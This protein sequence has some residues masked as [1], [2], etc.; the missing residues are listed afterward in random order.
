MSADIPA[1]L[2][3]ENQREE[4]Q[5]RP[6]Q[7]DESPY[8]TLAANLPGGA[9]FLVDRDLRYVIAEGKA[10]EAA[11]F[12]PRQLEG[13]TIRE[14]LDPATATRYEPYY[15]R[16]LHGESFAYEHHSHGRYFFS[17]GTP[18]RN[19]AGE[20]THV[21]AVSYDVTERRRTEENLR[22][23]LEGGQT[24]LWDYDFQ[25]EEMTWSS[26][27]YDLLGRE[28]TGEPS[29]E[30]FFSYIHEEDRPRVSEHAERW[31][32]EGGEFRDEF[33]ILRPDGQ[34]RWLVS[35]AQLFRDPDGRR[36]RAT[37]VNYD[38][39]ERKEAEQELRLLNETL[40]HRVAER[41]AEVERKSDQLRALAAELSRAEQR[42]RRRLAAILHDHIQQ[43]LVGARMQLEWLRWE[44]DTERFQTIMQEMD[45]ILQEALD[46][47]RNL[48]VSISP[49]VL[50]ETGLIGGLNWLASRMEEKH[51]FHVNLRADTRAEPP[52]EETRSLLFECARELLFNA[53]KHAEVQ[54]A[55]V[56]VLRK[57]GQVRV[58]VDD[59]GAG[60]NPDLLHKR[61]NGDT[62]F[63]LFSIQERL[64]HVGGSMAL[65]SSPGKGT[66][67]TL[68]V[69]VE[70]QPEQADA[71]KEKNEPARTI[72]T[73]R[74]DQLCR[75]LIVDDHK[76]MREGLAGVL[77]FESDI[78]VVGE[79]ADGDQA[80]KLADEL[81]PDVVIMDVN[82]GQVSGVEATRRITSRDPQVQVIGLSMHSDREVA[83]AMRAAGATAF[84]AKGGPSRDLIQSIRVCHGSDSH[85]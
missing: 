66:T 74:K 54:E 56:T 10:L 60:F 36:L 20:V 34:E 43:L 29:F 45:G 37:G 84:L 75:V 63:G 79:A 61:T 85:D 30:E 55:D 22:L 72:R 65:D 2:S 58:I 80:V 42:E 77:Q 64:A 59:R 7:R 57:E 13:K 6:D 11:G 62:T 51:Q 78:E 15:R 25:T 47:A 69:P 28:P 32:E 48:T 18:I 82:L 76:I 5:R 81:G 71:A 26:T 73:R 46:S 83:S 38:I 3:D 41:T 12:T 68:I 31:L 16:A 35:R 27:L 23:A 40:E 17:H 44:K 53:I 67:V 4:A 33:R 19:D 24:G 14:A 52:S 39:T 21:L 49:P 70:D 9:V 1:G 50:P 8:R